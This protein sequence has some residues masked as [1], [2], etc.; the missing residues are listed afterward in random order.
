MKMTPIICKTMMCVYIISEFE[1]GR[2]VSQEN[3]FDYSDG[4][5]D[6]DEDGGAVDVENQ[7]YTA[8]CKPVYYKREHS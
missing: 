6:G 2:P 4:G 1:L 3:E 8:K 7:Y 5:D